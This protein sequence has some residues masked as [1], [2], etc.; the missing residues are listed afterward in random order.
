MREP[1][2]S[3]VDPVERAVLVLRPVA[4][5]GR[6]LLVRIM[7]MRCQLTDT[8]IEMSG[9]ADWPS[10]ARAG[11]KRARIPVSISL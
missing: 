6:D 7:G 10:V 11:V 1:E 3:G 4:G 9:A 5:R 8:I 2:L